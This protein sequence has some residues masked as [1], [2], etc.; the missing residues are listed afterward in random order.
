MVAPLSRSPLPGSPL[1]DASVE[2]D[3]AD[4]AEDTEGP[5]ASDGTDGGA[6]AGGAVSKSPEAEGAGGAPCGSNPLPTG[7][8]GTEPGAPAADG[9]RGVVGPASGEVKGATGGE[10]GA[11]G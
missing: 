2:T 3:E 1:P 4:D 6:D 7:S 8:L 9:V 10:G 5:L 11:N